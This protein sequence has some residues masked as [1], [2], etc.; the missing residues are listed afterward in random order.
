MRKMSTFAV[1]VLLATASCKSDKAQSLT[2]GERVDYYCGDLARDLDHAAETYAQVAPSLDDGQLSPEQRARAV[3]KLAID[4]IGLSTDVRYAKMQGIYKTLLFCVGAR[5]VD[6]KR[7]DEIDA[8]AGAITQALDEQDLDAPSV[9][10][11]MS[12]VEAATELRELAGIAR[13]VSVTPRQP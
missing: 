9:Q 13:E 12:H 10:A 4:G 11:G 6:G 5:Q 3:S 8:R 7:A 2:L 1:V